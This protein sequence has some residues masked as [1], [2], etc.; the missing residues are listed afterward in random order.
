MLEG[1]TGYDRMVLALLTDNCER[2]PSERHGR[3]SGRARDEP[4]VEGEE[5]GVLQFKQAIRQVRI[6]LHVTGLC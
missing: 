3:R 4:L 2:S 5:M 1:A 6:Y